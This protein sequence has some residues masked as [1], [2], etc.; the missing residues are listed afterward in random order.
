MAGAGHNDQA[1]AGDQAAGDLHQRRR[2][3]LV[4]LPA[5]EQHRRCYR[6]QGLAAGGDLRVALQ[7]PQAQNAL[8]GLELVRPVLVQ[9]PDLDRKSVV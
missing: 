6:R 5:D 2:H 7:R 4:V 1:G 9:Q 3:Y 8:F